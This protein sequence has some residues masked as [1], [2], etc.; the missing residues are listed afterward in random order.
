MHVL[1]KMPRSWRFFTS[2]SSC[3][4]G[5]LGCSYSVRRELSRVRSDCRKLRAVERKKG[6]RIVHLIGEV[7]RLSVLA[8]GRER[9]AVEQREKVEILHKLLASKED[10]TRSLDSF[11]RKIISA[12]QAHE[13]S[14]AMFL[15]VVKEMVGKAMTNSSGREKRRNLNDSHV[16]LNPSRASG[17]IKR[18]SGHGAASRAT[19]VGQP[20]LSL[21]NSSISVGPIESLVGNLDAIERAEREIEESLG[22]KMVDNSVKPRV[23]AVN[24]AQSTSNA[25]TDAKE[26][27]GI[28]H[29][30]QGSATVSSARNSSAD[31]LPGIELLDEDVEVVAGGTHVHEELHAGGVPSTVGDE[32]SDV[33]S[34]TISDW[35]GRGDGDG[36]KE[37]SGSLGS[38]VDNSDLLAVLEGGGTSRA[39]IDSDED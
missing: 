5:V 30:S 15:R 20:R 3:S 29:V 21:V 37:L 32:F 24:L 12:V 4:A 14:P 17:T 39:I 19:H 10:R 36:L 13:D 2:K 6:E 9:E 33:S 22:L 16:P 8:D 18:P 26:G 38:D 25:G 28:Q 35:E 31:V 11:R 1:F 7:E 27:T 23:V 34:G